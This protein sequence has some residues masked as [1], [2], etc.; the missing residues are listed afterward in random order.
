MVSPAEE[1]D[2]DAFHT[3]YTNTKVACM[4]EAIVQQRDVVK[5][6]RNVMPTCDG[7]IV[8]VKHSVTRGFPI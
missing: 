5:P 4:N 1:L 2:Q 3:K 7:T 6:N 8:T